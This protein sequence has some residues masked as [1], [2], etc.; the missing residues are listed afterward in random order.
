MIH[1]SQH[2]G[3]WLSRSTMACIYLAA[4][5]CGAASAHERWPSIP[6]PG[7]VSSYP[8]ANEVMANGVPMRIQGFVSPL[9]PEATISA[10][11]RIH[12]GAIVESQAANG[13]TLGRP[14]GRH[15][16]TIQVMPMGQQSRGVISLTALSTSTSNRMGS[17]VRD[18]LDR[19]PHG[20]KV[21]SH[22]VSHDRGARRLT[23]IV[24]NQSS[25]SENVARATALLR[26]SGLALV[27]ADEA[28]G[29]VTRSRT[30]WFEGV[31]KD[32]I[33]AMRPTP[34]RGSILV[35]AIADHNTETR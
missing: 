25:E 33:V 18:M 31:A 27:R 8:I 13:R 32:G 23:L 11:K 29:A 15:Y 22:T 10:F 9:S 7:N 34:G 28:K 17:E 1:F 20:S 2:Q 5:V 6:L 14:W 21:I 12:G 4:A 35:I 19:L 26:E 30:L 16:L 3:R 24:A